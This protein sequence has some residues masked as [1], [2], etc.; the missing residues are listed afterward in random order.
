MDS[1]RT[2]KVKIINPRTMIVAVD[3]GKGFHFGYFRGPNGEERKPFLLPTLQ[4][5]SMSFGVA[6]KSFSENMRLKRLWLVLNRVAPMLNLCS[7]T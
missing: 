1:S 7:I 2:Q 5:V 3:I 4:R 6:P